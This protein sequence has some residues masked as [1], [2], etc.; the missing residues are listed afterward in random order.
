M[1][2]LNQPAPTSVHTF[3][4]VPKYPSNYCLSINC[5][6]NPHFTHSSSSLQLQNNFITP[7]FV[8]GDEKYVS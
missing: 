1:P 2:F 7:H 8:C 5:I 4:P 3:V 6:L